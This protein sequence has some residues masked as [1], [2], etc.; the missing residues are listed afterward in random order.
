[1]ETSQ[2]PRL[3]SARAWFVT[4]A[5]FLSS[6]IVFGFLYAFGVFLRP[7]AAAFGVGH[8]VMS[9][10]FSFICLLSYILGPF[11]GD[12]AD[13]FGPRRVL[14]AGSL[15]FAASLI[16]TA[17]STNFVLAFFTLGVGVGTARACVFAPST[18]A[19][20]EWFKRYRDIA[21][22]ISSSGIGVGILLGLPL[23]AWL[24]ESDGWRE[25]LK[26]LGIGG[27]ILLLVSS[28]MMASPPIK[29]TGKKGDGAVRKKVRTR[30]FWVF[31][32]S[33]TF[34]GV[35]VFLALVYLPALAAAKGIGHLS[36]AV[37]VAY[38]GGASVLSRIGFNAL[39][40]KL[41]PVRLYQISSLCVAAGCI[42]W[43][44]ADS[45][46]LLI[47]FAAALGIG[48]GGLAALTAPVVIRLF[49][50]EDVGEVLGIAMTSWGVASV[51]GPP[52]AGLLVDWRGDYIGV[53]WC[54]FVSAALSAI[55]AL[56]MSGSRTPEAEPA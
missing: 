41:G 9:S 29:V 52:L 23:A 53:P 7:M 30:A 39:A 28:L 35:P 11:T 26:V 14:F 18:A 12:L 34:S 10:L 16:A 27:G 47:V 48:Y 49:G 22:G 31:Y 19:V 25:T 50:L 5:A 37:L 43:I 24:L 17:Y 20:G 32:L 4:G 36:A 8:A 44:Y 3:D 21:L 56:A 2:P 51:V 45:L 42:V 15:F 55:V 38:V 46:S 33:R 1:M 40:E 6:F 13:H 54:A